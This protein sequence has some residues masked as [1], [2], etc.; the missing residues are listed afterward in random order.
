[1]LDIAAT[2]WLGFLSMGKSRL[3]L[4]SRATL[5]F[6]LSIHDNL[7]LTGPQMPPDATV[8]KSTNLDVKNAG[9]LSAS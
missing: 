1:M 9:N 6:A 7:L 2:Y 8:R 5:P 4:Q 3:T